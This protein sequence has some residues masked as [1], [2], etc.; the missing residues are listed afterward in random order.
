MSQLEVRE[1]LSTLLI[2]VASVKGQAWKLR[3]NKKTSLVLS[4]YHSLRAI[5]DVVRTNPQIK[6]KL[7][8]LNY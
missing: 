2:T 4:F 7:N 3:D 6:I 5:K 8:E 1:N